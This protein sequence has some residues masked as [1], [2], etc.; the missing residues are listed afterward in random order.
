MENK[1]NHLFNWRDKRQ[2]GL[3]ENDDTRLNDSNRLTD[4]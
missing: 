3:V 1:N 4:A 2:D